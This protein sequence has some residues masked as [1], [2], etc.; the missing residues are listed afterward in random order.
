MPNC[1]NEGQDT[2]RSSPPLEAADSDSQRFGDQPSWFDP[3]VA[4]LQAQ[5]AH[6]TFACN[7]P[8]LESVLINIED[9]RRLVDKDLTADSVF[10]PTITVGVTSTV[11]DKSLEDW[12]PQKEVDYVEEFGP[13]I[14]IPSD[15]PI[16]EDQTPAH[17]QE[18]LGRYLN[19]LEEIVKDLEEHPV[20]IL[21]LVKGVTPEE[22]HRCFARFEQLDLKKY[23]YYCVQYFQEGN[24]RREL[25]HDVH[26]IARE[27]DAEDFLL[28]GLQATK[29]LSEMPPVVTAA[30]GL[31][32]IDGSGLREEGMTR[33]DIQNSYG[34]FKRAVEKAIHGGQ[35]GLSRWTGE[36]E[37]AY[38][39]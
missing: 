15:R 21:P 5:N 25:I 17:R 36:T 30:A 34:E 20:S 29:T 7:N 3:V 27:S 28:I 37:V 4:R 22:R 33:Q 38:G 9:M 13:D 39:D 1:E 16:Y 6:L 2:T 14:Y 12:F 31:A 19:D 23:A 10:D 8:G 24:Y 26:A 11:P 18:V 32:W 35:T